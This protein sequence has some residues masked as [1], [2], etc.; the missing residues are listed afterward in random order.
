MHPAYNCLL[1][2]P[3][4]LL[5]SLADARTYLVDFGTT[6][7]WRGISTP[8][9]DLNGNHWNGI[10]IGVGPSPYRANMVDTSGVINNITF[11]FST[12][13]GTDSYNGPAGATDSATLTTNLQATDIDAAALG[14][15]G[16]KQAA[17]DFVNGTNVRFEIGGLDPLLTYDLVFFGSAKFNSDS[18]SLYEAYTD[19]AYTLLA[20]S[21]TLNV[22]TPGSAWLHNR[23]QTATLRN[24][25]PSAG[26]SIYIQLRGTAGGAGYLNAMQIIEGVRPI[27]GRD[28]AYIKVLHPSSGRQLVAQTDGSTKVT[29][30]SAT[31]LRAHWYLFSRADTSVVFIRNR[32][33]GEALRAAT[34][35]GS[36]V[37]APYDPEDPRQTWKLETLSVPGA[38]VSRLRIDGTQAALSAGVD[39]A[40]ATVSA[41]DSA[42]ANQNWIL[43][44][45]ERGGLFPWTSYDED[46]SP[47]LTGGAAVVRSAY[48][49]GPLPLAAE[50]Q[51]R[52]LIELTA[53][54]AKVRWTTSAA[55]DVMTLRYSV[56]DG[57][58]G[59]L[60]LKITDPSNNVRTQKVPVTS[61]QAWVYLDAQG[62]ENQTPGTGRIPGKRFN[63]AR[64]KLSQSFPAGSTLELSRETGDL[65]ASVDLLET[66]VAENVSPAN[67]AD[68]LNVRDYGAVGN[69]IANDTPALKTCLF[70]AQLDGKGVYL[71]AG[72]YRLTEEVTL[73]AGMEL[74]G[75]GMWRTELIF[76]QATATL[77]GGQGL[78]GI[79]ASGSNTMVRDLYL[80]SA[81]TARDYGYKGLKGYWGTGS[82]IEN[83]WVDQAETGAWIADFSNDAALFTDGLI[84]RNCRL[85]NCFADGVNYASGT[86]NSVVE[87]CHVRGCG[88][89]GIAAWASGRNNNKPTTRNQQFRYNTVECVY[90][91]GGIGVFGGEGHKIHHNLVRDQVAGPGLRFNTVFVYLG[92]TLAGYPFGSQVIQVYE[93][94]LERT[95]SL[96]NYGE[97]SGAIELQ[98]QYTK[99]E[100]IRFTNI[101][102]VTTQYQ[103]IR[104]SRLDYIPVTPIP[105]FANLTFT[106]LTFSGSPLGVLIEANTYG[107]AS[108]STSASVNDLSPNFSL[109][110]PPP[111]LPTLSSFSPASGAPGTTVTLNGSGLASLTSVK[112][113]TA[114]ASFS[115]SSDNLVTAVVPAGAVTAK[116]SVENT[117]GLALSATSFTVQQVN[118]APAPSLGLPGSVTLPL[119]AG[120]RLLASATDDGQPSG[121]TLAYLWTVVS[122]PAGGVAAFDDAT[123][124]NTAVAFNLAGSYLLRL[125]VTD[126]ELT[127]SVDL[128][129]S[130]GLP[131]TGSGQD[132]GAVALA[133]A[134][135]S[136]GGVWTL[137]ASGVDIYDYADGFHFRYAALNGDGFIQARLLSQTN[138]DPWAKAG[139]MIRDE[140]TPGSTHAFLAGTVANGL[141]LQ[142][143]P[144]AGGL[145]LH[146]P[147]G[148]YSYGT[149]LRIVRTGSTIS[150]FKSVN[151]TTWTPVGTSVA[152]SMSGTVY[153]GL[154][155]TSHNNAALSTATFDN[156]QGSGFGTPAL[157]VLA[158]AD[159]TLEVGQS[160]TL[161]GTAAGAVSTQWQKVSGPGT[162]S[163]GS[164]T[165]LSTTVSASAAGTYRLRLVANDGTLQTFDELVVSVED[166]TK[167]PAMVTLAGLTTTYDGNAKPVTATTSPS[168]LNVEITYNG[169]LTAPSAAGNY[170][171]QATIQ[172]ANY[173]GTASGTLVIGKATATL[174]L[175]GLTPTYDGQ[176]KTA[177]ATTTP[178]NLGVTFAYDGSP[179]APIQA[180]SYAVIAA[181]NDANYQGTA[182]G[183]MAIA[184]AVATL[185]LTD[186]NQTY[187]G[188]AINAGATTI[189]AGLNVAFTYNG[190]ATPPTQAG[191]YSVT[192]TIQDDNYQ[193]T[194]SGSLVVAKATANVT[195]GN[196]SAVYN[197][198]PRAATAS[199][200]PTG[201]PLS[202]TYNGSSIPPTAVGTYAVIGTVQDPN[203]EGTGT[204]NLVIGAAVTAKGIVL[205]DFGTIQTTS[206]T[207][208]L[209]WNNCTSVGTLTN[210]VTTNNV[211][212]GFTLTLT[213]GS[214][215]GGDWV[216]VMTAQMGLF[217]VSNAARDGLISVPEDGVRTVKI[218]GLNASLTYR[219]GIFAGKSI[220]EKR[221]T[222]Y[223]VRGA[224]TNSGA[225]TTSGSGISS[226][227]YNNRNILTFT[228]LVPDSTGALYLDYQTMIGSYAHLNAISIE[229]V[230]PGGSAGPRMDSV[231]VD[232]GGVTTPSPTSGRHWNN[233]GAAVP[234]L[235]NLINSGGTN[236]GIRLEFTGGN[237]TNNDSLAVSPNAT[238]GVFN[239]SNAVVDGMYT[240]DAN[241]G[242]TLKLS[243]LNRSNTYQ[244]K[245]F[246]SRG[247]PERRLTLYTVTGQGTNQATLVTSGTNMSSGSTNYNHTMVAVLTN[248]IPDTN[249][250]LSVNYRVVGGQFAYLNAMELSYPAA[251]N[252][253]E[254]WQVTYFPG[255]P[256]GTLAQLLADPDRDGWSNLLEFAQG[257]N[258]N[259]SSGSGLGLQVSTNPSSTNG[260]SFSFRRRGG[261]GTG[262]TETGY[263]VDGVTYT[264][265]ASPTLTTPNWQTGS[266]VIQQV[267][268]PVNNG[269]GTE[270]VTVRI[271]GTNPA[272]FLKMEISTP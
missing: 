197:G 211:R 221:A 246:G 39:G 135:S 239:V 114:S 149:W 166:S 1:V 131:A 95:G 146:E 45:L 177:S 151:G 234:L 42:N 160:G 222:L 270:T 66:E 86:R 27:D 9:P 125:N 106:G 191:T 214:F 26:G 216:P 192:G 13:F 269:D 35:S 251:L 240:P 162:V 25:K 100:N 53:V 194:A 107:S 80:K 253:L 155:V 143:R 33:T 264:L 238:L 156:L 271:L 215:G 190:S 163:F 46:G 254:T 244:L 90:R 249:G 195:L 208:G 127:G 113:G 217:Q 6:D 7:S 24:I 229:E 130:H 41:Y 57:S 144:T 237:V 81:Q 31:E 159:Q 93:N 5:G 74:Q 245:L 108:L 96:S 85:R 164:A 225:L 152:P 183:T 43:P 158:G 186:L 19:S 16:I 109:T 105:V 126:G 184:K 97:P 82:L 58:A 256:T 133:G 259:T 148:S 36:V 170:P 265:K 241:T 176:Q 139:L 185:N 207:G 84:M 137:K 142:N 252:A 196:L 204:G 119:G 48:L 124:P 23:N 188:L 223:R 150:A 138:T 38:K 180:G 165:S 111:P 91:A 116:I 120:L 15:L 17:F 8:S 257:G 181:I 3:I 161:A 21:A 178:A 248:L 209:Y 11:G 51:K 72:T 28:V 87:N 55:M 123:L 47:V 205:V 10:P 141:A 268:T 247:D 49:E 250:A 128:T 70:A 171:V 262:S 224:S 110:A 154:A 30:P 71:P 68:F 104:F 157:T 18:T 20:S 220:N 206:P 168:G 50:A 187:D 122:A 231:L 99:V 65:A 147:L 173:R 60:T 29:F 115:V 200:D 202:L 228:N 92:S 226:V 129:V 121:G 258:P 64:I 63:E 132:V 175:E 169:S 193:G 79:K 118:Q 52:G 76:S 61:A 2:V 134:S 22:H 89:D 179:T 54:G 174:T 140:L 236:A 145:S 243:G 266:N 73:P 199:T 272:C 112:F 167:T 102:I 77:Y 94:T 212:S 117:S 32:I 182:S 198:S 255:D 233:A 213:N 218:G 34:D 210:L 88:D 136:S 14:L 242:T 227:N 189:P 37:T 12:P 75:A 69:G 62:V 201:L 44:E 83:V 235:T 267:G 232:F 219:L 153:I 78:G 67:L 103:A 172:N 59:T 56:A 261:S 4:L 260:P 230:A 263:T 40:P 98:T 203:Y 101:D